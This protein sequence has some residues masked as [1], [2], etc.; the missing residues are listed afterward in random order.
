MHGNNDKVVDYFTA[1]R[2]ELSVVEVTF[3]K[4]LNYV[5]KPIL[6][7]FGVKYIFIM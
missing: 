3:F 2:I 7:T 6:L 5:D 4:H 1:M